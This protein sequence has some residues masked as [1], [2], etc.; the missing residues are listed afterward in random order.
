[1][2]V[3]VVSLGFLLPA[4]AVAA[5]GGALMQ[6]PGTAGCVSEDGTMGTCM[7]GSGLLRVAVVAVSPDGRYVY[8]AA[9]D[10]SAVTTFARNPTTGSLSQLNGVAGCVSANGDGVTCA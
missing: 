5:T 4:T 2:L 3:T 9:F 10:S 8:V 1:V 6:E 7:D